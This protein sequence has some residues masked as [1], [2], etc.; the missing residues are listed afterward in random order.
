MFRYADLPG[1][2]WVGLDATSG[3]MAGEGHIPLACTP[4]LFI[5][6]AMKGGT[7]AAFYYLNGSAE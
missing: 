7:T 6:G 3:L 5:I 4:Q 2:G 1:A